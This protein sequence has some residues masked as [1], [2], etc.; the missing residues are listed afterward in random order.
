[1][2][3][4]ISDEKNVYFKRTIR[5]LNGL[6]EDFLKKTQCSIPRIKNYKIFVLAM[7]CNFNFSLVN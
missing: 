6:Q 4:K 5:A 1:M 2:K 3:K 7:F